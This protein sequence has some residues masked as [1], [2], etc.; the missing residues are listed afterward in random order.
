MDCDI[1]CSA[2]RVAAVNNGDQLA[3][4][5]EHKDGALLNEFCT[6]Y[7]KRIG[8]SVTL[9]GRQI[10]RHMM[11]YI[12]ET[13]EGI[14]DHTGNAIVYGDSITGDSIIRTS[15]GDMSIAELFTQCMNQ[16]EAEGKE[17]GTDDEIEVIGFD[18]LDMEPIQDAKINY[19]MRH[20]TSKQLYRVTTENGKQITVTGDHSLMV[21]RDG[22]LIEC[23]PNDIQE[24]DL[25]ITV[26]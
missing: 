8:Q 9:S 26:L 2:S 11:S 24:Q 5:P 20:K 6:F 7:D 1:V 17:Y 16:Y 14:Y 12:N 21:D 13:V 3:N 10:V 4:G 18:S 25:I 19:V 23:K 22:Y 15:K